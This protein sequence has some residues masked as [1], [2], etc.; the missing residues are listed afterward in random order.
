VEAILAIIGII[1]FYA[2]LGAALKGLGAAT[3]AA[4]RTVTGK[5]S[6]SDNFD[7]EW[8]GMGPLAARAT[9][10]RINLGGRDFDALEVSIRG[11]INANRVSQLRIVT[12]IFDFTQG[13][14]APVTCAIDDFQERRSRVFQNVIEAGDIKPNQGFPGW[15]KVA[16]I[17][18]ESLT[19]A[20]SGKRKLK[21]LVRAAPPEAVDKI[22]HGLHEKDAEIFS[23][24]SCD[25]EI[26]LK[27]K[28]YSESAQERQKAK[29]L[30]VKIAV[31]VGMPKG[32]LSEEKARVI[33]KWIKQE[34][35][36]VA[37]GSRESLK[38]LLNDSLRDAYAGAQKGGLAIDHLIRQLK[39]LGLKAQNMELLQLCIDIIGAEARIDADGMRQARS[40]ATSLGIDYEEFQAMSDKKLLELGTI[41][42]TDNSIETLLGIDPS[43]D[44]N[45]I[46]GHLRAEF[47]KWN[48]RIQTLADGGE[49]DQAQRMLDAIAAARTKYGSS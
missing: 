28:G 43:W 38:K 31:S 16:T 20:Y 13:E 22:E 5:G 18:P 8:N 35:D 40:L 19:A 12:S 48:G 4:A 26:E 44:A 10:T 25:L 36:A 3:K 45:R 37:E 41:A 42:T 30:S 27:E 49:K 17:F 47:I 39:E 34:V 9:P 29:G 23:S 46:K 1:V 2:F 7:V 15:V 11:L 14:Y 32:V 24:A 21:I 33:Q 6:F